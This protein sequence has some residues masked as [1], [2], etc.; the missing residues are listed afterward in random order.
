MVCLALLLVFCILTFNMNIMNEKIEK[1]N[2]KLKQNDLCKA[3]KTLE[4]L[5]MFTV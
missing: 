4:N 3:L 2:K 5:N 1:K